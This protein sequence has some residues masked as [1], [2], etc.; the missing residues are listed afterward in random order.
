MQVTLEEHRTD[1]VEQA[2]P[3]RD[4]GEANVDP[5]FLWSE[6]DDNPCP[7]PQ[8]RKMPKEDAKKYIQRILSRVDDIGKKKDE[9]VY[10]SYCDMNNHPRFSRNHFYKHQSHQTP[11]EALMHIVHGTHPPF[12]CARAQVNNGIAKPHWSRRQTK[13]AIDQ[14]RAPDLR[15]HPEGNLPPPVEPPQ[16]PLME[17]SEQQAPQEPAPEDTAPLCAAAVTMHGQPPSRSRPMSNLCRLSSNFIKTS[18]MYSI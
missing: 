10:C 1:P 11:R 14:N 13:L 4:I 7:A 6:S 8:S 2:H 17:T 15:W 5:A 16:A 9:R 18:M 12:L 3:W